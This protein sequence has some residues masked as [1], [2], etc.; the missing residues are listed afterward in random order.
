MR[1]PPSLLCITSPSSSPRFNVLH[2]NHLSIP[3]HAPGS[4]SAHFG[5]FVNP[6]RHATPHHL[7]GAFSS[8]IV[9][10]RRYFFK[11]YGNVR[12]KRRSEPKPHRSSNKSKWS[13]ELESE[14]PSRPFTEVPQPIPEDQL[15]PPGRIEGWPT[16]IISQYDVDK[17]LRPLYRRGWSIEYRRKKHEKGDR[18]SVPS[19]QLYFENLGWKEFFALGDFI[20]K[21]EKSEKVSIPTVKYTTSMFNSVILQHNVEW[22]YMDRAGLGFKSLH[23]LKLPLPSPVVLLLRTHTAT[24][25]RNSGAN[26]I[27]ED[28]LMSKTI[29]GITLRDIRFAILL[30]AFLRQYNADESSGY[31]IM[32]RKRI[33]GLE[34]AN[35]PFRLDRLLTGALHLLKPTVWRKRKRGPK[36]LTDAEFYLGSDWSAVLGQAKAESEQL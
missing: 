32:I 20:A 10:S 19:L 7:A 18:Y 29:E 25:L 2:G 26:D 31:H 34:N 4:P 3:K 12:P 30:D 21:L 16:P 5:Y 36:E 27:I 24:L 8:P 22:K 35:R 15:E 23:D 11:T 13:K 6:L 14:K 28:S 1:I 9:Q 17:Y 33:D